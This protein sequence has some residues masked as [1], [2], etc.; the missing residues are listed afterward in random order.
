MRQGWE[1]NLRTTL[2]PCQQVAIRFLP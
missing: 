2:G 1:N